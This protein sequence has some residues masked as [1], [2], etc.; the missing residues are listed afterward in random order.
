MKVL[1]V[2]YE[3]IR[4]YVWFLRENINDVI[5]DNYY[6]AKYALVLEKV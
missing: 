5:G 3:G 2:M 4:S 1:K 6:N